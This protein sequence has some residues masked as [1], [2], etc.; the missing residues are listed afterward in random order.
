M[1]DTVKM[2]TMN[3]AKPFVELVA[4]ATMQ[5]NFGLPVMSAKDGSMENV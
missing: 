1:R 3:I 4:E 5:M 2:M